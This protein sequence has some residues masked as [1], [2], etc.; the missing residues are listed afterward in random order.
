MLT[1]SS[2]QSRKVVTIKQNIT[3]PQDLWEEYSRECMLAKQDPASFLAIIIK[4]GLDNLLHRDARI[5]Q[6]FR[7]KRLK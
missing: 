2:T 5:L 7:Q 6:Q 4:D 1:P 3:L